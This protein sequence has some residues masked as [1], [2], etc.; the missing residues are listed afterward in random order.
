MPQ[1]GNSDPVTVGPQLC[2]VVLHLTASRV[3]GWRDDHLEKQNPT[4]KINREKPKNPHFLQGTWHKMQKS[5]MSWF[6]VD[7]RFLSQKMPIQHHGSL[8]LHKGK[9]FDSCHETIHL[10]GWNPKNA[11]EPQ[12]I[13]V[14][15][16]T[17]MPNKHCTY[18]SKILRMHWPL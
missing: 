4:T 13:L 14:P 3:P 9:V 11:R 8:V 15:H 18:I 2:Q 6:L 10:Q 1:V 7:V 5:F 17:L 12:L 16:P